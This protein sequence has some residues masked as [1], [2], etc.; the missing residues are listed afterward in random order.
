MKIYLSPLAEYK[1]TRLTEYLEDEWGTASKIKFLN[2]LT[3]KFE[4][5]SLQPESS[6]LTEDF[7]SVY[8]SVVTHQCSIYYRI[9]GDE[10]EIITITDN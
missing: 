3:K 1:L 4:Q 2:K 10:V 8:W 5:I 6:S 9:Q 7:D